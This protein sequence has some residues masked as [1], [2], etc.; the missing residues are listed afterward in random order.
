MRY[1][2]M[3][4]LAVTVLVLE[5][6]TNLKAA[7]V[8][9]ELINLK[10]RWAE[11]EDKRDTS[12]LDR[13]LADDFVAG[14]ARGDVINK[15]QLIQRIKSPDRRVDEHHSDEIQ[16]RVYGKVAVMI[17]H[18]TIWGVDKGKR[19]G[20]QFRFI[21]IFVKQHGKWRAVLAQATPLTSEPSGSK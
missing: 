19:F 16:V 21:R 3:V 12:F 13:I 10:Q 7:D 5:P 14:T 18:T 9:Q 4:V 20:G 1:A 15:E 6:A 17:D 2:Q 11:A 8:V